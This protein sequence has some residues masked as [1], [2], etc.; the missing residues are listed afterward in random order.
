MPS[1]VKGRSVY[2]PGQG[3]HGATNTT[4]SALPQDPPAN[5]A[6]G[7]DDPL[8][9]HGD[10]TPSD[11]SNGGHASDG[12]HAPPPPSSAY[13]SSPPISPPF[14]LSTD[15]AG[16]PDPH[17]TTSTSQTAT[18][19]AST[20]SKRKQSALS[21]SLLTSSKKQRT[22]VTGAVALNG[23]K[24]SLD[25]FNSTIERS[26]LMQPDRM[27]SDTSPERRAKAMD[28]F[29]E[30]ESYLSDDCMVAFI[31]LFRV[32]SAAADAYIALKRDGLRKAWVQRQMKDLGF[33]LI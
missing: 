13:P 6:L 31:D 9:T 14:P 16:T 7:I 28:L 10:G 25:S 20:S 26:L 4:L 30:Q 23:I 5:N 11:G 19:T 18:T 32:D 12:D 27:R 1:L 3:T 2:R 15:S 8:E 21:A 17:S 33:P 24:E 29:Q 22:A